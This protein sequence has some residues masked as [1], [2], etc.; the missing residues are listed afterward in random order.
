MKNQTIKALAICAISTAAVAANAIS[1]E[2]SDFSGSENVITFEPGFGFQEA[3]LTYEGITFS[4]NGSGSGGSGFNASGNWGGFFSNIGGSSQGRGFNDQWGQ[5]AITLG[6]T[7]SVRRIGALFSTTPTTE[8]TMTAFDAGNN[9]LDSVTKS[10]PGD[11]QAVFIGLETNAD[12]AYA[13]ISETFDNGHISLMD[14]VRFEA[15]PEPASMI[16]LGAGLLALVR[17]RRSK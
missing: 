14:D 11:T 1:I 8:W 9:V 3:P 13:T 15:V 17:R 7:S 16:A 4:E 2:I 5:S 10:M 6:T 12:I